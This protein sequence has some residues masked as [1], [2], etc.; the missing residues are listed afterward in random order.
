VPLW[1]DVSNILG[2]KSNS[3]PA[4][5]AAYLDSWATHLQHAREAVKASLQRHQALLRGR[6]PPD[7]S[8]FQ[9]EGRP[10]DLA[11]PAAVAAAE[12]EATAEVGAGDGGAPDQ[13]R[14]LP[15]PSSTTGEKGRF[16][17]RKQ[18]AHQAQGGVGAAGNS[19]NDA[20]RRKHRQ[21]SSPPPPR[22]LPQPGPRGRCPR[23]KQRHGMR[24]AAAAAQVPPPEAM[25]VEQTRPG[26]GG[27]RGKSADA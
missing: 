6:Q 18:G 12:P 4:D 22:Q 5:A 15:R 19:A 14:R 1:P 25:Q 13:R 8:A 23:R 21:T 10:A 16:S 2:R 11:P 20:E 17:P 27:K 9:F 3:L 26:R 24:R 7:T